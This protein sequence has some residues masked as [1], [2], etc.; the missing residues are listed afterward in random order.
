MNEHAPE[1]EESVALSSRAR[2][3]RATRHRI[4]GNPFSVRA[5]ETP[6]NQELLYG[7][8]APLALEIGFGRGQFLLDLAAKRP[9]WNVLGLEIRDHFVESAIKRAKEQSLP[10]LHAVVANANIHLG[11]LVEDASVGFVS[12]N[13]PDPWFKKRHQKR[14]VI[15]DEFLDLLDQKFIEGGE[16]HIMTDFQP[17]GEEALEMLSAHPRF[18]SLSGEDTFLSASSTNIRSEREDTHEGRG[19][20]IYRVAYKTKAKE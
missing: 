12:I 4:H 2:R 20:P 5:P 7:R 17:I 1:T 8:T 9:Q 11:E 10:N 14:R 3:R 6:L 19:D 18:E 13:F 16:L 15:R